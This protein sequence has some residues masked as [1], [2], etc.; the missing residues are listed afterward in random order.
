MASAKVEAIG[1]PRDADML[2]KQLGIRVQRVK[3]SA[4]TDR[5]M[6]S[7]G[8]KHSVMLVACNMLPPLLAWAA[9]CTSAQVHEVLGK[10]LAKHIRSLV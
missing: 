2:C 10:Q 1:L 6:V 4:T 8:G 5:V 9:E 7:Y 3:V